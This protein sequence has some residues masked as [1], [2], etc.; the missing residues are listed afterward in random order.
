[1][2]DLFAGEIES[3]ASKMENHIRQSYDAVIRVIETNE[4]DRIKV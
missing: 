1:V 4:T 2:E 3:A